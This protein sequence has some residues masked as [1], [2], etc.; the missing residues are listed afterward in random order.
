MGCGGSEVVGSRGGGVWW[1]QRVE[2]R[3][4]EDRG[5]GSMVVLSMGGRDLTWKDLVCIDLDHICKG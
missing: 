1:D 5:R 3:G 2:S 4:G